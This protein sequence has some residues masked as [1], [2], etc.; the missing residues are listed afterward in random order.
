[1]AEN[2]LEFT[3]K[4]FSKVLFSGSGISVDA[5]LDRAD[6]IRVHDERQQALFL[7][8][9]QTGSVLFCFDVEEDSLYYLEV[10]SD[11]TKLERKISD[12]VKAL[13][14]ARDSVEAEGQVFAQALLEARGKKTSGTVRYRGKVFSQTVCW[15]KA[16]YRS[17]ANEKGEVYAIVGYNDVLEEDF[18]ESNEDPSRSMDK[19]Y[20]GEALAQRVT[21]R[22]RGLQIG[23][24]GVLFLFSIRNFAESHD[25]AGRMTSFYL[26][27]IV[28]AIR[29]DFRGEDIIGKVRENVFLV[30]IC[31]ETSI[32]IIERRAQRILDICQRVPMTEG[33]PTLCNVGVA[34]SSSGRQ[35]FAVMLKQAETALAAAQERGDNQYRLFEE[36]KY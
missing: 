21:T 29:S 36:E 2:I 3:S 30:F 19:L 10:L 15:N 28:E 8:L 32:D 35:Q 13:H 25:P 33:S 9:E 31:G 6:G 27:A 24:K 11:G 22:L 16:S 5:C 4:G 17:L 7:L 14:A 23:E 18:S 12:F 34:A 1:M 26:R 20:E